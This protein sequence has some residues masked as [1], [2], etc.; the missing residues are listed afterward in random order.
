MAELEFRTFAWRVVASHVITY[1]AAG[2]LAFTIFDYHTLYAETEL[3][4]L[5][6]STESAWVAAGPALQV[7]RG[8]LFAI[9]LWPFADRLISERR[10]GVHLYGLLLGLAVLGTA[11]P[12]P[13]SLEGLYFTTLPLPIHLVGLPEVVVQTGLFAAML[14]GW[15]RKP[16]RWMN[17]AASVA[18]VL[19]VLMSTAGMLAAL[20]L[21]E[22]A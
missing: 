12:S 10:G 17:V 13:G 7:V 16:A 3:R 15:C 8:L 5:M 19:I 20:G 22:P 21:L 11:G 9:V 6:R 14:V 18:V 1:F 2:L 4:Y